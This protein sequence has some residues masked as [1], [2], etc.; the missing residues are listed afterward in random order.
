MDQTTAG[1]PDFTD[2]ALRHHKALL[3]TPPGHKAREWI[4]AGMHV[5]PADAIRRWGLGWAEHG[6]WAGRVVFPYRRPDDSIPGL[7]GRSL[8]GGAKWL[9]TA[10]SLGFVKSREL[11]GLD[12]PTAELMRAKGLAVVVEGAKDVVR[13]W[14][15]DPELPVVAP[16]GVAFSGHQMRM[17]ADL[18]VEEVI[19]LADNDDGGDRMCKTIARL[20]GQFPA[21]RFWDHREP[22][23]RGKDPAD[24]DDEQLAEAISFQA[25]RPLWAEPKKKRPDP[26]LWDAARRGVE[27]KRDAAKAAIR[28]RTSITALVAETT[29]STD[30]VQQCPF[31]DDNAPSLS[32]TESN[33][34]WHCFACADDEGGI[35]GGDIF[36][37]VM[38]RDRTGFAEAFDTLAEKA[39]VAR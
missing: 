37:W 27:S 2:E 24:L 3:D 36:S 21:M 28:R 22:M 14:A 29:G 1:P 8:Q 12:A 31:H 6:W 26:D 18:G 38:A 11:W 25:E 5:E 17:L 16:V 32:V 39:G 13:L 9:G 4:Q 34:L 30:A 15:H 33:G 10:A 19:V 7:C 23:P 20:A 35:S